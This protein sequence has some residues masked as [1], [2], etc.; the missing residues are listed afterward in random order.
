MSKRRYKRLTGVQPSLPVTEINRK[1]QPTVYKHKT[2]TVERLTALF[3]LNSIKG[4]GPA[5]FKLIHEQ[6]LSPESIV[7]NPDRLPVFGKVG[8]KLR[9]Q[10]RSVSA[11]H[12]NLCRDR[13]LR[14]LDAAEINSSFILTYESEF[15]PESIYQSNHA[16]PILYVRGSPSLLGSQSIAV[17]GSRKI[18]APYTEREREFVL[19]AC[20]LKQSISSGFA[21]GADTLG[22]QTA[23]ENNGR[24]ICVMPCGLNRIFPPE[25]RK[26]WEKFLSYEHAVFVS[27]F[28]FGMGASSLNLR[29]RNKLIV[30]L[31]RGV[32]VAQSTSKGGA[33]NAYRFG[34]ELKKPIS[35]F[36]GDNSQ[37]TSGNRVIEESFKATVFAA[38]QTNDSSYKKWILSL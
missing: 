38:D 30:A 26:L 9:R 22:H 17:V 6:G 37:D 16:L 18:R 19:T 27:E 35:T 11:D 5:K 33:M 8:V 25:N 13:A 29:K 7:D 4:F 21:V 1:V 2:P 32:L 34:S 36:K 14:Q 20:N 28:A 31:S 24:T 10:L 15:Y 23:F 12:S 3:V